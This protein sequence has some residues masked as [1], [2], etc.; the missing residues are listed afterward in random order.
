MDI[1]YSVLT[2]VD[3]YASLLFHAKNKKYNMCNHL[4]EFDT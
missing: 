1:F 2:V 3:K 4:K